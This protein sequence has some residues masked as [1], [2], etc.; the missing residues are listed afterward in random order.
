MA[1]R[2]RTRVSEV[3]R[4]AR[5]FNKVWELL[6]KPF[7]LWLLSTLAVGGLAFLFTNYTTCRTAVNNDRES[8]SNIIRELNYRGDLL[9]RYL[10]NVTL[11]IERAIGGMLR[12]IARDPVFR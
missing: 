12:V 4:A 3:S 11:V 10:G 6:N 7:A 8:I 2:R 1:T 5:N 9:N